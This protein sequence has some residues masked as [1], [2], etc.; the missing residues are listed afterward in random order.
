M[1][2]LDKKMKIEIILGIILPTIVAYASF[3]L[4][5]NLFKVDLGIYR[6]FVVI[7]FTLITIYVIRENKKEWEEIQGQI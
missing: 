4:L 3:F 7:P 2:K 1:F 5:Y 6:W